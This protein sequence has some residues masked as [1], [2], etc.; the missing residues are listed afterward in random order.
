MTDQPRTEPDD[1]RDSSEVVT[2][3]IGDAKLVDPKQAEAL[4]AD[5]DRLPGVEIEDPDEGITEGT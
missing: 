2:G 4:G 5:L 3:P 1:E